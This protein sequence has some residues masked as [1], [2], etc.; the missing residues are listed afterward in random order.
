MPAD[1]LPA[2]EGPV[3]TVQ[4]LH[5]ALTGTAGYPGMLPAY[6]GIGKD[7]TSFDI[8]FMEFF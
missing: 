3:G 8:N 5:N 4:I 6:L 7:D 2:D 1:P